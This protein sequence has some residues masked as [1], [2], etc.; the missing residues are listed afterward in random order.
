[1][2]LKIEKVKYSGKINETP[3]GT[4]KVVVGGQAAYPFHD[5]EGALP[6]KP[7]FALQVWDVNPEDSFPP[8]LAEAYAGVL[9]D[10]AAWAKKAVDYGADIISLHLKSSDPNG[11]D[12]GPEEAVETVG[13][14]LAA[15][16]VPVIVFGVDNADKDNKTLS[17]VAAAF[18]NKNL[19][20]GPLTDKNYKQIGA[21]ALAYGHS[22]IARTPIDV[23]LAK[24]LNI[25][26]MDLGLKNDKI[27]IDP[28]T[29][30]LGYGME[31]CYSVM[32]RI[33]IAALIQADDKLQQPIVNILGEEIW[34]LKEVNQLT[35]EH[36][37]LGDQFSR[38]VLMETTE[39]VSLL[40]AGS[41]LLVMAHP[42]TLRLVRDYVD[43][44]FEGG[45]IVAEEFDVPI[46][47]L[48]GVAEPASGKKAEA[49]AAAP[50]PAAEV[51]KAE[52]PPAPAAEIKKAEPATAPVEEKKAEAPPA[53]AVEEKK[54]EP[55]AHPAPVEEKKPEP[56]PASV[57]EK[58]AEPAPAPVEEKKPEPA[59]AS[60]EEKKAEPAPAPV[61]EKKPEPAQASVEEK[62]AEPAPAPV[63]EKKPEPAPASVE[64]KK[65]EP[66]PAPVEEKKPE[67]APAPVEEKRAEAS[68]TTHKKKDRHEA[69]Y[70]SEPY[71]FVK[72]EFL[73]STQIINELDR[74]HM[75]TPRY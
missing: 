1:M 2:P 58:K 22:V 6:N 4:Q 27:L 30:G 41:S 16:D 39:A 10:P 62:K 70:P 9:G 44:M 21:Q 33:T 45:D 36:P 42:A 49:P 11:A 31:Y 17:A 48:G 69:E 61:E 37:A 59:P 54:S 40:G 51:K 52:A 67:S 5:F 29:G 66:A 63:E 35:A 18:P 15:V 32:E 71:V 19:V 57:E 20:L 75:R 7:K 68:P 23:N 24:Q 13:K 14:V 34:K 64:E 8:P 65:A 46:T 60:V 25:L 38:G 3:L 43:S 26:L 28:N 50:A 73:V 47:D 55:P 72:P 56:S 12:T 53:P 74:V